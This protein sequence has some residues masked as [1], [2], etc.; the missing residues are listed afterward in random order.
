MRRRSIS[1]HLLAVDVHVLVVA[2]ALP[3]PGPGA[4]V[5]V[6]VLAEVAE[7]ARDGAVR[8]HPA[9]VTGALRQRG[10]ASAVPAHSTEVRKK[11]KLQKRWT[12]SYFHQLWY[13][14]DISSDTHNQILGCGRCVYLLG[15]HAT[16]VLK[17]PIPTPQRA[18]S[19][20]HDPELTCC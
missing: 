19:F 13:Q 12:F 9:G 14:T 18:D 15:E 10:P 7:A 3:A 20:H 1:P 8:Q 16:N 11:R 4:A 6:E 17:L 5:L 2:A